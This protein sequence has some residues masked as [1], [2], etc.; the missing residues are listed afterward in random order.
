MLSRS[1]QVVM[2]TQRTYS[3][4]QPDHGREADRKSLNPGMPLWIRSSS[5]P[6]RGSDEIQAREVPPFSR[7]YSELVILEI[8]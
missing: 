3:I 7:N 1:P 4:G 2:Q 5:I 8:Q 6:R